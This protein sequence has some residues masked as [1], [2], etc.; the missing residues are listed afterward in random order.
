METMMTSGSML[1]F[2]GV[3]V[4][5]NRDYPKS[6]ISIGFSIIFTIH[7]GVPLFLEKPT[8]TL[9][10]PG[11]GEGCQFTTPNLFVHNQASKPLP[12]IGEMR[13]PP[14]LRRY[15]FLEEKKKSEISLQKWAQQ[16]RFYNWG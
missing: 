13:S 8:Y 11:I 14:L 1:N 9:M 2:G 15:G 3:G 10:T 16:K 12:H 5:K 4:S 6:S 7:L